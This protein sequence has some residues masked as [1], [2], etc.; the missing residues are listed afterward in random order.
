MKHIK[1]EVPEREDWKP[2]EN[3]II[4]VSHLTQDFGL[5]MGVFDVS[6]SI[7]KGEVYGFLG[8]NGAGKSTTIRHIMGFYRPQSGRTYINGLESFDNYSQILKNIGYLPGEPAL[9]LSYTG[10]EFIDEMKRLKG[11]KD[12]TMLNHLISYFECDPNIPC[13]AMSL[14]MKRKIAIVVTFMSDPDVLVLDEPTSGLD[15]L[16]QEKFISFIK[17]EK[18]RNKTILL[19]SHIFQ[20]VDATCDRIGIIK[21][22]KIVS[23][24]LAD[25]L[26]HASLKTYKVVFADQCSFDSMTHTDFHGQLKY[27]SADNDQ[28]ALTLSVEDKDIHVL[29]DALSNYQIADFVQIKETLQDYFLSFYKENQDFS[30][31]RK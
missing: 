13:K 27:V 19:S 24:V 10:T 20:E 1:T 5:G 30:G 23:E 12:E 7:R 6:F 28:R 16:M 2:K 26:K 31:V 8:P 3:E 14:G 11:V 18:T 25:N 17:E 22:G 15:P 29:I 21:D 9:P 4:K